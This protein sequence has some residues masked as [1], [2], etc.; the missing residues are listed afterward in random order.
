MSRTLLSVNNYNYARGGAESV[1]LN[2]NQLFR[3][4]GWRVVPFAMNHPNNEPSEF[5]S[6]FVDEIEFGADYS[7]VEKLSMAPKVIYSVEAKKKIRKLIDE[8]RP[9]LCHAHNIYHHLSPSILSA[10][11]DRGLP[12]VMTVHDLKIACPAYKMLTHDGVCERCQG[13]KLRNLVLNRCI[14][15]SFALSSLIYFE[16]RLHRLLSTYSKC[17]DQLLVPS[18]FYISKLVEWGFS[19]SQM[20]YVPNYIDAEDFRVRDKPGEHFAFVGR[21]APEKGIET[22]IHAS[23]QAGTKLKIVGTGPIEDQLR[24]LAIRLGGD[25]EFTGV[26]SGLELRMAIAAARALV[27]PSEWFENAPVSI[28][29]AYATG[30]P[31]IGADIG[32]IPEMIDQ[33]DTGYV[34]DSGSVSDLAATLTDFSNLPDTEVLAMGTRARELV[35]NRFSQS[36]YMRRVKR[37]YADLGVTESC[38]G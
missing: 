16:S 12:V 31:V 23:R 13:G 18:R 25:V 27:L 38:R 30:V 9:D 5:E 19:E 34:F 17:I 10:A 22:L 11:K 24:S 6:Y 33:G 3:D 7:F 29:E 35:E 37:V 8:V 2:H 28:L 14:K 32:G 36:A 4:E 1:F 15:D 21:L 20:T 26:L